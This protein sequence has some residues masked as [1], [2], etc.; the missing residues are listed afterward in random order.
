MIDNG[1]SDG[2]ASGRRKLQPTGDYGTGYCRPP[3]DHQFEPGNRAN[4]RGRKKGS[5]NRKLVIQE[6]LFEPVAVRVGEEVKKMP[7][8]EAILKTTVN[9]ALKGDHKAALTIIGLAQKEGLLTPE[10]NDAVEES[11]S[12]NDKA[13]LADFKRRMGK[14][15]T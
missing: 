2:R 3:K 15:E 5:R 8:L 1:N 7:A 6:V 13:I 4:P 10:Q 11:L 9:R 12:D 14:P